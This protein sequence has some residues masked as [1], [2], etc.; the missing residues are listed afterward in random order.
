[1][2]HGCQAGKH[3]ETRAGIY[4]DR[5]MRGKEFYLT[6]KLGAFGTT[7]SLL[8]NF[9][10]S[11]WSKSGTGLSPADQSWLIAQ[12]GFALRAVGRLAEAV[13]PLEASARAGVTAGD[14]KSASARLG[15]LS[16]LHLTLGNVTAA[17]DA[18]RRSVE[19]ADKSG[20]GFERECERTTLANALHQS[21]DLA[22]ASRLFE[23]VEK[24]HAKRR[25]EY[26]VL[27]S[28]RGFQYC[29]LLRSQ[30]QLAEV[31]RRANKTLQWATE[32]GSLLWIALDHLSLGHFDEAVNGLRRAGTLHYLPRGLLE[33][34]AH[35]RETKAWDKAQHDLDE[36]RILA[37]RCGM[38]LFLT[39]YHLEQAR[40]ILAQDASNKDAARPHYK[41]PNNSSKTPVT[42]AAT[43]NA[44]N[45]RLHSQLKRTP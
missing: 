13:E 44:T 18:A 32:Y 10:E 43:K 41:K 8:A 38:R 11:P 33:R 14:W 39:D 4:R 34:A 17:I 42:T 37:T 5:I 9:F 30:G 28:I 15:N 25:P 36:V 45:S 31:H 1:V 26:R 21:G 23:E 22:Q 12:A 19:Y 20:D 40:V 7:L 35:Y 29:D 16:E 27:Y 24:M 6:K 3:A 2:Y